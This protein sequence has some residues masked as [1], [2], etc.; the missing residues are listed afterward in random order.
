MSKRKSVIINATFVAFKKESALMP[1]HECSNKQNSYMNVQ[2]LPSIKYMHSAARKTS[3]DPSE[4]K[5]YFMY[6]LL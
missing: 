5:D 2:H 1:L 3:V 4:H 6:Q